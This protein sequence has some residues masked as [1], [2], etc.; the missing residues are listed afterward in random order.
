M[1]PEQQLY[2]GNENCLACP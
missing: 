1:I 2:V